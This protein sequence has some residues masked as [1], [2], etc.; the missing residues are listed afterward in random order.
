MQIASQ[1]ASFYGEMWCILSVKMA[2]IVFSSVGACTVL[3]LGLHSLLLRYLKA[4]VGECA[5]ISVILRHDEV[6]H[7]LVV[8]A[9]CCGAAGESAGER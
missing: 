4:F 2:Y 8:D 1:Y 7:P 3:M 9:H 5:K 6:E